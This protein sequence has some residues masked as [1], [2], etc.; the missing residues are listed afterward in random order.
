MH[1]EMKQS[2]YIVCPKCKND[3]SFNCF[4]DRLDYGIFEIKIACRKCDWVS[5]ELY[6]ETG[7]FPDLNLESIRYHVKTLHDMQQ[8]E[9]QGG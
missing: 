1:F 8:E 9:K 6:E 5:D 2:Q 3:T 4:G 7:Y